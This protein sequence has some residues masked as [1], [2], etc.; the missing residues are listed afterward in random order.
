MLFAQLKCQSLAH[1]SSYRPDPEAIATDAFSLNWSNLKFYAFPLFSVTPPVLNK[2]TTE[3]A[4]GI[5][6]LP[7]WPTPIMVPQSYPTTQTK[8]SA[9]KS[10]ER[11]TSTAKPSQGKSSDLAQVKPPR[12]SLIR[13]GLNKYALSLAAKDVLMAS[14]RDGTS[15]QYHTYLNKWNQYCRDKNIDVFQ[16][17]ITNGIEFIVSLY[18][19]GLRYSA[20]NTACSALSSMLVLED[21]VKFGE[22][23]LVACCMK[24]I[25]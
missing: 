25:F 13:E 2:L 1:T 23:P 17:G 6:P 18:K 21:R 8:P 5:C 20:I 3:G 9:S 24:G 15:K 12:M 10:Q 19:S 11:L 16:P 22:H 7:D 14:W 4:Q